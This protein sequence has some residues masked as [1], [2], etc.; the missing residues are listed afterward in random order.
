MEAK[1]S[2]V[3]DVPLQHKK[4]GLFLIIACALMI[5]HCN[6]SKV[7]FFGLC[8]IC[9]SF[10]PLKTR[11]SHQRSLIICLSAYLSICVA[12]KLQKKGCK[13]RRHHFL[14]FECPFCYSFY[15]SICYLTNKITA[16]SPI[17][18]RIYA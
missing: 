7:F 3:N 18:I 17:H 4:F 13:Y 15:L 8:T 16:L 14:S 1:V 2:P 11:S 9:I 5:Y 10:T 12:T 6:A